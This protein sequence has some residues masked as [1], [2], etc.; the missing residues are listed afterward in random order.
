MEVPAEPS[1]A[2]TLTSTE[3]RMLGM[4]AE[5]ADVKTIAQALFL[6]PRTVEVTLESVRDRVGGDLDGVLAA[7]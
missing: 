6:T 4:L 3:R 7:S 5:G 1:G 2:L